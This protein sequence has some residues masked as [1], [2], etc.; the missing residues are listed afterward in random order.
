ML[1]IAGFAH[2]RYHCKSFISEFRAISKVVEFTLSAGYL[3]EILENTTFSNGCPIMHAIFARKPFPNNM[4]A[5]SKCKS[6]SIFYWKFRISN[7][8][9]VL[10][11]AGYPIKDIIVNLG[12]F[13][14]QDQ[15]LWKLYPAWVGIWWKFWKIYFFMYCPIMHA[16]LLLT[17][18]P[19]HEE[20]FQNVNL[21]YFLLKIHISNG[22]NVLNIAGNPIKD[23][24]VNLSFLCVFRIKSCAKYTLPQLGIW[25][26][27]WKIYFFM[28]CP[29][30]HAKFAINLF[31]N[32]MRAIS[33]C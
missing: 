30:M 32:H 9:N 14:V 7:G 26:K 12:H 4:R 1:N 25:W 31:P 29:I 23:I 11:I 15:I 28:Y 22:C 24:I 2:K 27:F 19:S 33:K 17:F 18:S 5:I 13:W 10:N 6:Y 16:N 20:P 8:C 3:V 21:L